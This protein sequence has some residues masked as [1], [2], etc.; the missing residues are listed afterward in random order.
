MNKIFIGCFLGVMLGAGAHAA[1][2]GCT[3]PENNY[4]NP[5]VALCSTHVYNLGG[6]QNP[7]NYAARQM[8][9]DVV[10]LKTTLITQQMKKQY[11]YLDATIRRLKTQ[12]EKAVITSALESAGASSG[13]NGTSGGGTSSRYTKVYLNDAENCDKGTNSAVFECLSNNY[14]LINN[15]TNYGSKM[16]VNARKQLAWDCEVAGNAIGKSSDFANCIKYDDIKTRDNLSSCMS[17]VMAAI[18][19]YNEDQEN[20]YYNSYKRP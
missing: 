12:L 18:R 11:D 14:K 1:D 4:V 6:T 16:D 10:A 9:N 15:A 3:N 19:A 8:M 7:T 13:D 5:M 20:K 17:K 2:N